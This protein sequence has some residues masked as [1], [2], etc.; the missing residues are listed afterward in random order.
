LIKGEITNDNIKSLETNKNKHTICQV[1]YDAA[2]EENLYL[3][4]NVYFKL[5]REKSQ[6]NS[7]TFSFGT[8]KKKSK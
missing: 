8:Q 3:V 6:T 1:I 4:V 2:K 5:K 7:L